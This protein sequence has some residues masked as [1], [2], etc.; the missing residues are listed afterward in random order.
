MCL[1]QSSTLYLPALFMTQNQSIQPTFFE[2]EPSLWR[3]ECH[4]T[5]Q[6]PGPACVTCSALVLAWLCCMTAAVI[7]VT[8][9]LL[10]GCVQPEL[11]G[12]PMESTRGP[13]LCL[14]SLAGLIKYNCIKLQVP[15]LHLITLWK[16]LCKNS[17]IQQLMTHLRS[18]LLCDSSKTNL[19]ESKA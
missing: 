7:S 13:D 15:L 2:M 6:S 8:A 9:P 16:C 18:C 17:A 3:A 1:H 14:Q 10:Q 19:N 5:Y 4:C 11:Y 12:H